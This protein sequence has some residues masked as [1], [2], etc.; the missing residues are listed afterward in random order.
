MELKQLLELEQE[1]L[2][3]HELA[4]RDELTGIMNRRAAQNKI[5][6]T[7]H[8]GGALFV[9]DLDNFKHINDRFGHLTGDHCIK[10]A[11]E[12]LRQSVR[13]TDVFG[14][15]GG[16]EFVIF[17]YGIS[18]QSEIDVVC[19]NIEN[20]FVNEMQQTVYDLRISIAGS[21]CR[22]GDTY[23]SLFDRADQKLLLIKQQKKNSFRA[24]EAVSSSLN[25]DVSY[26]KRDL[27]EQIRKPGA[28]CQDYESF[29]N[30]YRF[31]ERSLRRKKID[32]SLIVL[33]I[34]DENGQVLDPHTN[35]YR[36]DELGTVLQNQIRLG[37]VYTR[38]SS[39]QFLVMLVAATYEQAQMIGQRIIKA[40]GEHEGAVVTANSIPLSEAKID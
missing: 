30:I 28:F 40:F 3:L 4:T 24:E 33:S 37:D 15:I 23:D 7:M 26:I 16:D 13:K 39:N 2:R 20:R 19:R 22:M 38:Y 36:M 31:M 5:I 14:R 11:S 25:R 8:K 35:M 34:T 17:V 9:C 1:N 21:I 27:T 6:E 32:A 12:L 10:M 29:K 18:T